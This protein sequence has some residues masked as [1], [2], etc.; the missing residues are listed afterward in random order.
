MVTRYLICDDNVDSLQP[1][2]IQTKGNN[3]TSKAKQL[4]RKGKI[5]LV[6]NVLDIEG[7]G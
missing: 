6:A 4:E 1:E 7:L 3:T 5:P 2:G